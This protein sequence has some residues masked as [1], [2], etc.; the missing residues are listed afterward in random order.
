MPTN[1]QLNGSTYSIP[2]TGDSS[3]S[4]SGAVD[5]YLVALASGVLQKAGGAFTL[6]AEVDFGAS[7]GLK[8][9]YIKSRGTTPATAGVLR[10]A[11]AEAL[12]WRNQ[13][14]GAN[15]DLKVNSSNVLEFNGNPLVTLALGTADQPLKMNAAGT[16]Y[17]WG[18]LSDANIASAAAIALN[19]LA[20]LTVSKALVSDSSGFITTSATSATELGY[21]TGVTSAVQT[22]LTTNA[23]NIAT[24]TSTLS[25]HTGASTGVHGVVGS[26]LGTSDTQ[27]VTNKNLASATNTLTG[28]TAASFT[29]T[30]TITLPTSTDTLVGKATTDTLTNKTL[31]GPVI[32]NHVEYTEGAAPSTPASGKGRTFVSTDGKF[33]FL[34]D[35][36]LTKTLGD[37]GTG[38]I[39]LIGAPSDATGWTETGTRFNNYPVTTT[40]AGDLPLSGV[41]ETAIQIV[42]S[43]TVAGDETTDYVS[44]A[45]TTPASLTGKL[46]VQFYMRPG[47]NFAASEWTVSVYQSTTRQSLSTDSSSLTYLP[48]ASG[49]F[50]TT[51]DAVAST[52]YTLRFTRRVAGSAVAATLNLA[53]VIVGPG[54]A[55]QGA[56]VGT[57]QAYTPTFVG[58]GT[59][60][61]VDFTWRQVGT[62][63]HITGKWTTG[64][65]TAVTASISLP[66]GYTSVATTAILAGKWVR[67]NSAG[68]D[69][70]K[71]GVVLLTAAGGTTLNLS[72]DDYHSAFNPAVAQLGNSVFG[73][74]TP[75]ILDGEIIVPIAEWAGSGT[76]NLAQN[77]VQYYSGVGTWGTSSSPT[78][79]SGPSGSV[80][81]TTTPASTAFTYT[82]TPSTPIPVGAKAVVEVSVDGT[83]WSSL[84]CIATPSFI[85]NLRND[86][87]N[88]LGIGVAQN[89]SGSLLVTFGKY[90]GGTTN[91]WTGT[92]YWRVAVGLPGQ[93]VGF[94]EVVPGIS[95]G[96]VSS[97]GLKG[98]SGTAVAAGYVG[99]V[100]SGTG[101]LVNA[102]GSGTPTNIASTGALNGGVWAISAALNYYNTSATGAA[103]GRLYISTAS[104]SSSGTTDGLTA[105]NMAYAGGSVDTQSITSPVVFVTVAAGAT[106]T[107]YLNASSSYT[108]GP[109]RWSGSIQAVRIA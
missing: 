85:E 70:V 105:I 24:T 104:A 72:I 101:S 28:A 36:G 9:L 108:G 17:E 87:T 79:V 98:N 6:S 11:N 31:T 51:F 77:D 41:I 95:S 55:A 76:V 30:G 97:S 35:D 43:T 63:M 94:G 7:Y 88:Y 56:V 13:A 2:R 10:L 96:L 52:A 78:L 3:W 22:Q 100:K 92:W 46:K 33:K 59:C 102:G 58:F 34:N 89:S 26:V 75:Y 50:T 57:P 71:Q 60:T 74:A 86:G 21:L 66:T 106:P 5:D 62:K 45:F 103:A 14:N 25:T 82:I 19:K 44:Y 54:I 38:E 91:L 48:N 65:A 83:H 32:T 68:A 107:Y 81:G 20:A 27:T 4:A 109:P 16:A 12:S 29:N 73:D 47:T 23:T 53:S 99:E 64:T 42:S 93:A 37:S 39:N 8:A 61:G 69:V 15:L 80:G 1:V 90:A 40:T 67:S 49:K 18:K 84:P